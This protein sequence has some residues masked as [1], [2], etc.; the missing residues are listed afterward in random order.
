MLEAQIIRKHDD[1]FFDHKAGSQ[2]G[3][4]DQLVSLFTAYEIEQLGPALAKDEGKENSIRPSVYAGLGAALS[5]TVLFTVMG[6]L[7]TLG[8]P[9]AAA[10][11]PSLV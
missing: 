2:Q 11:A 10:V 1:L 4:I 7:A 9:D 3:P 5:T 8:L 6:F